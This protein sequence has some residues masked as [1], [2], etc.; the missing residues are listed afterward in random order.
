MFLV[1][2]PGFLNYT[3]YP[4]ILRNTETKE[5]GVEAKLMIWILDSDGTPAIFDEVL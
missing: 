4:N 2:F 1:V 3:T 5:F